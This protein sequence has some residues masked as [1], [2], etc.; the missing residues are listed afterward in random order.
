MIYSY[1]LYEPSGSAG[2]PGSPQPCE[3]HGSFQASFSSSFRGFPSTSWAVHC[4]KVYR[5]VNVRVPLTSGKYHLHEQGYEAAV[6]VQVEATV[7]LSRLAR[8]KLCHST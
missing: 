1:I 4:K 3:S 7:S 5:G 2:V 6:R 8:G